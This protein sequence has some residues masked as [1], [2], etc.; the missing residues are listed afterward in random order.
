MLRNKLNASD[1]APAA[2]ADG[3]TGGNKKPADFA[4]GFLFRDP[5]YSSMTSNEA[6]TG[7]A[8]GSDML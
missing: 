6:G 8:I 7:T 3:A 2:A 4:A 5:D 1:V